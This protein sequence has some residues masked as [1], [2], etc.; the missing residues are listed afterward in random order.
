MKNNYG[1]LL[2]KSDDDGEIIEVT[3]VTEE[4]VFL[5]TMIE[6]QERIIRSYRKEFLPDVFPEEGT[7]L[8]H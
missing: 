2:T 4:I 6:Y 3:D 5:Y 8:T 7:Q 1:Y